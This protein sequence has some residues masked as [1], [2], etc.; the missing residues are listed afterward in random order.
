MNLSF[1]LDEARYPIRMRWFLA[2]AW[3]LIL[4][5][6]AAVAWAIDHWN[7]PIHAAWV[8][9]PTLLIATL[10]TGLWLGAGDE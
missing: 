3:L 5:K 1:H 6:C 9:V 8:I 2:G 7:V 10:A 4:A